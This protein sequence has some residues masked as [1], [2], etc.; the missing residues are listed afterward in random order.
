MKTVAVDSAA[1][2]VEDRKELLSNMSE[3]Q[4]IGDD[5]LLNAVYYNM[6]LVCKEKN[7]EVGENLTNEGVMY[8]DFESALSYYL[9]Y[10]IMKEET[11]E[12]LEF[13]DIIDFL[14]LGRK[15]KEDI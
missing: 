12:I 15:I 11:P 9:K 14:Y 10:G 3:K 4:V 13:K 5:P 8:S 7:K 1:M 6:Y 2:W